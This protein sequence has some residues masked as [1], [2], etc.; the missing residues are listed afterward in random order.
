METG[1]CHS[2]GLW[3]DEVSVCPGCG[4]VQAEASAST[5]DKVRCAEHADR[6]AAF[7]CT[8]C[9]RFGCAQCQVEDSGDCWSCLPHQ[10]QALAAK[11]A[12][13]RR[14]I[15]GCVL[16]FAVLAPLSAALANQLPLAFTC[17]VACALSVVISVRA[18]LRRDTSIMALSFLGVTCIPLLFLLSLTPLAAVPLAIGL[19]AFTQVTRMGQ[20]EIEHWRLAKQS[21]R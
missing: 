18:Y 21:G 12:S 5:L 15:F 9:G 8:R 6:I 4:A 7:A 20:L 11:V 13:V 14:R 3:L 10:T 19:F 2:C 1:E 17:A 16:A